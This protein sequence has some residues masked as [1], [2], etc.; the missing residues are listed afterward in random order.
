MT[1]AA[2]LGLTVGHVIQVESEV[3]IVKSVNRTANTIDVVARGAGSTSAAAHADTTAFTVIGFAGRD[4]DLKNVESI[5][6]GYKRLFKL[7]SDCF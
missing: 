1:A 7:C 3:V 2:V 6:E 4:L 5:S